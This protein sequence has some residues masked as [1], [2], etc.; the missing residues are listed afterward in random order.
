MGENKDR[1]AV[2]SFGKVHG[3][4][5]L[6]VSDGSIL[7]DSPGV[8]PQGSIMALARRNAIHFLNK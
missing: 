1:C 8:N 4:E 2:N 7:C 3:W 5:D 6:Y